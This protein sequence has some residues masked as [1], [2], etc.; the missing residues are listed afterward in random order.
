MDVI[1]G[2]C[3][4]GPLST[5]DHQRF[6]GIMAWHGARLRSRRR[7]LAR[8]RAEASGRRMAE[9]AAYLVDQVFP[10]VPVRQW[11]LTVPHRLR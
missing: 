8:V 2:F 3:G 10:A 1:R 5:P 11:V 7:G 4:A 6:K 9:R